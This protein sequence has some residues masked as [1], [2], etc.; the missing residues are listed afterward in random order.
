MAHW[1]I[2]LRCSAKNWFL[3]NE[4]HENSSSST[5]WRGQLYRI[6]Y[7]SLDKFETVTGPIFKKPTIVDK[8]L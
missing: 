5:A 7:R 6:L 1:K 3:G 8:F 4:F 2:L